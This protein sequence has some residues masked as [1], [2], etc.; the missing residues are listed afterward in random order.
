MRGRFTTRIAALAL[1][2]PVLASAAPAPLRIGLAVPLS[3]PDADFGQGMRLGAEQAVA[4]INRGGGVA[5]AKLQLVVQDDAGD[6]KQGVEV[7]RK[8]AA[9]GVKLVVGHLN[10][11]VSAAALP[12][13]DEAGI[14]MVTPGATWTALT[15][16]GAWNVFRVC[17]NDAQ[18]GRIAGAWIAERLGDKPV[19]ILNDKTSFGRGLADEVARAL[20]AG[21]GREALFEG[22]ARGEKDFS[23]LV[24]RMRGLKVDAVYFG[25]LSADAAPLL[26]ALREGG[27]TG[28]FVGSDGILDK[29]FAQNAG[30]GALG[31]LMTFGPEPKKLPDPKDGART[32]RS[33]E[34]EMFAGRT[35]AAV[36]VLKQAVEAAKSSEAR[37]VA[38][39]LRAGKPLRTAIGEIA[40][41]ARGDLVKPPYTMMLWRRTPDGRIDYAGNEA[42]R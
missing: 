6:T 15:G 32:P 20:K 24:T 1:L 29:D 21:G 35:Y 23:G 40:F 30:P 13:Y 22:I 39:V 26:R 34:A 19:A 27:Y 2:W 8:F 11:G 28:P 3:G 7:A 4:D 10:S 25:G 9:E 41:D 31:T 37:K 18:Q 5:G 33:P 16:R 12:V 38:E 42:S 36:E 17:G 14:V